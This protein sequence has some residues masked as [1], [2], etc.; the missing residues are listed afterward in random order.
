MNRINDSSYIRYDNACSDSY[1]KNIIMT[2]FNTFSELC[3][4]MHDKMNISQ[5]CLIQNNKYF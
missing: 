4:S 5:K 2:L 3:K 1:F